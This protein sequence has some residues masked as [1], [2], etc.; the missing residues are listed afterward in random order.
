MIPDMIVTIFQ[1]VGRTY[2][3]DGN[4]KVWVFAHG[5][6]KEHARISFLPPVVQ[7]VPFTP[8]PDIRNDR[9]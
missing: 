2:S 4:G 6:W 8:P 5:A 1:Y 9:Q 7:P 3:I